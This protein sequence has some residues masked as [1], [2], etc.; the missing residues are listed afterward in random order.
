MPVLTL[1]QLHEVFAS[2]SFC[3]GVGP[4]IDREYSALSGTRADAALARGSRSIPARFLE[5]ASGINL[6]LN[7]GNS[8][9]HSGTVAAAK[10]AVLLG[11]RGIAFSTPADEQEPDF[12]GLKGTDRWALE[13]REISI[14]PLRLDLTDKEELERLR[15]Q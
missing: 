7:L 11:I 5:A 10:Q 9:W 6:G 15:N 12:E 14:T 2:D 4:S 8:I 13:R 3:A 1:R